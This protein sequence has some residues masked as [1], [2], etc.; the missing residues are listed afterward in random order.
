MCG[1]CD[2]SIF[3]QRLEN[4]NGEIFIIWTNSYLLS[5]QWH[6]SIKYNL[7]QA[8]AVHRNSMNR[9]LMFLFRQETKGIET[10]IWRNDYIR[11]AQSTLQ[12]D[13]NNQR[14]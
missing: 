7:S 13:S 6:L 10:P 1:K 8:N 14:K 2:S 4:Y 5:E 12:N 11:F 3:E 9:L